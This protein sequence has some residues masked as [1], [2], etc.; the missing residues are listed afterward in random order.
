MD[1]GEN[2]KVIYGAQQLA[3]KTLSRKELVTIPHPLAYT[4]FALA[5]FCLLVIDRKDTNHIWM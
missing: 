3:G 5:S 4:A 1:L 2:C